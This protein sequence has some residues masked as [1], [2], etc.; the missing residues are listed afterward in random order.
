MYSFHLAA[1]GCG[2]RLC[3]DKAH[4]HQPRGV[5]MCV[6]STC[7]QV[8]WTNCSNLLQELSRSILATGLGRTSELS[9]S[10]AEAVWKMHRAEGKL[11]LKDPNI[12]YWLWLQRESSGTFRADLQP[13]QAFIKQQYG[14]FALR[15]SAGGFLKLE[16]YS[17]LWWKTNYCRAQ[18][19]S[20]LEKKKCKKMK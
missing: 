7:L 2:R 15:F 6:E 9:C 16:K 8:C 18:I 13:R 20:D 19:E 11:D 10:P 5:S 17:Q 1:W 12:A 3:Q 14:V 4:L